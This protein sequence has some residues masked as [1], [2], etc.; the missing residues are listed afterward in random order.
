MDP[1]NA[2][3]RETAQYVIILARDH[4]DAYGYLVQEFSRDPDVKIVLDRRRVERR[5]GVQGHN[6]ER[7]RGERRRRSY[8]N[9]VLRRLGVK[10]VP[11]QLDGFGAL[12]S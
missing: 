9:D 5:R 12:T 3:G 6:P 1:P 11:V 4:A 2:R 8:P 10:V 7:R